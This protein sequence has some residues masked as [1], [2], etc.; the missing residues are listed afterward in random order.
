MSKDQI[1]DGCCKGMSRK[2]YNKHATP[3]Q[4]AYRNMLDGIEQ[5]VVAEIVY[6]QLPDDLPIR[7]Y[8][9]Y[10]LLP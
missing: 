2:L 9:G 3:N 6:L 10:K 4:V 1:P 8:T 5:T 7:K